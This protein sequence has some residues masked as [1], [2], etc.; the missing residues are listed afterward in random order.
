[1]A[2]SHDVKG[3][4]VATQTL[5][6]VRWARRMPTSSPAPPAS[7]PGRAREIPATYAKQDANAL[8]RRLFLAH[9][10]IRTSMRTRQEEGHVALRE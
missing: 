9:I 10:R 1:M 3:F 6:A 4:G 7:S 8:L 5:N 2:E